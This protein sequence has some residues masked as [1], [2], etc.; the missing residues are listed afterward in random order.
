MGI[1]INN[2]LD[3]L[4]TDWISPVT[5]AKGQI[6]EVPF[7]FWNERGEGF[8]DNPFKLGG[9][10]EIQIKCNPYNN[11]GS[12][13]KRFCKAIVDLSKVTSAVDLDFSVRVKTRDQL[14]V[15]RGSIIQDFK[16]SI[17]VR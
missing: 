15:E 14:Y 17:R 5:L 16:Y 2:E 3:N 11:S 9:A 7:S 10:G 12:G 13:E 4:L 1:Q 8:I 6:H